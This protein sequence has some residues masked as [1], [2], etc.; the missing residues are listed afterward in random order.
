MEQPNR[1]IFEG[2]IQP[3]D[4]IAKNGHFKEGD[5]PGTDTYDDGL[6]EKD[7]VVMP[8]STS[9]GSGGIYMEDIGPND[10]RRANEDDVARIEAAGL[11]VVDV[12]RQQTQIEGGRKD[13]E[14]EDDIHAG[15]D[16][17]A[18]WLR[19]NDPDWKKKRGKAA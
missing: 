13:E 1:R 8:G 17:A 10:L 5:L 3:I 14:P 4:E 18:K 16:E 11:T 15:E 9:T 2:G 12:A 6:N 19:E 7:K